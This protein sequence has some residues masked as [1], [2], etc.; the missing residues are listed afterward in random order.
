M[1]HLTAS[2]LFHVRN[3]HPCHVDQALEIGIQDPVHIVRVRIM[4]G[5]EALGQS[6]VVEQK[7][8][9]F[10]GLR[11]QTIR[12]FDRSS[13]PHIHLCNDNTGSGSD[14]GSVSVS[15]GPTI[16]FQMPFQFLQPVDSPGP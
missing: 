14:T 13:V 8:D 15:G 9:G 5:V 1:Q 12:R 7:L 2:S 3:D 6:G 4:H 10:P 11:Q 16:L